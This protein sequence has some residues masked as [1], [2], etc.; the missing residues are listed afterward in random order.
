MPSLEDKL[1]RVHKQA[2]VPIYCWIYHLRHY[3]LMCVDD[4]VHPV[5]DFFSHNIAV[6]CGENC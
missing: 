3:F 1:N 4:A 6:A 5:F 2:L